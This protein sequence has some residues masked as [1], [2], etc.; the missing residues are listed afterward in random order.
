MK[1][2]IPMS[3]LVFLA[4]LP[5]LILIMGFVFPMKSAGDTVAMRPPPVVF[6][7]AW[8]AFV[9]FLALAWVLIARQSKIYNIN[10]LAVLYVLLIMTLVL[11]IPAYSKEKKYGAWMIYLS[12]AFALPLAILSAGVNAYSSII[13]SVFIAWLVFA[14]T[15]NSQEV[16]GVVA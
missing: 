11:Y 14:G 4:A 16:Q 1:K 12:I 2:N 13:F 15:L 6:M 10:L 7:I 9:G 5:I 8:I 3:P